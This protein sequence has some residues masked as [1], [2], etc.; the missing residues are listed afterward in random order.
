ME[1]DPRIPAMAASDLVSASVL[2][3]LTGMLGAKDILSDGEVREI[4]VQALILLEE[5][6]GGDDSRLR[7]VYEAARSIIGAQLL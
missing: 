3:S 2:A 7:E 6:Q 1:D 4:Y 5:Q